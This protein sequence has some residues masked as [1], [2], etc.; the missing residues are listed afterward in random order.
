MP[1]CDHA[2]FRVADLDRSIAFYE[3]AFGMRRVRQ[4][5]SAILMSDD[6][7]SLAIL[8]N[9]TSHGALGHNGLQRVEAAYRQ[10]D[11]IRRYRDLY[12]Q[13]SL[14]EPPGSH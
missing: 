8:D 3:R 5:S 1:R 9:K 14:A 10:G 6:V 11:I 13:P 7:I 12:R 4:S 2:A